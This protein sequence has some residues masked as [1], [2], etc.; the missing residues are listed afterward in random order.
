MELGRG[1]SNAKG[2]KFLSLEPLFWQSES[3]EISWE[4]RAFSEGQR[5][6]AS[7]AT[8]GR[9]RLFW[10]RAK[11]DLIEQLASPPRQPALLER[12]VVSELCSD[13]ASVRGHL[14]VRGGQGRR[15]GQGCNCRRQRAAVQL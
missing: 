1:C 5:P 8:D 9:T 6:S 11:T 10:E 4:P 12:R 14:A 15:R 7:F 13:A 2:G 3:L